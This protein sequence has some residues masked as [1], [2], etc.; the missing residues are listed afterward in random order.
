MAQT[1]KADCERGRALYRPHW[2]NVDNASGR[3]K[4]VLFTD[5]LVWTGSQL[6]G[7]PC[8]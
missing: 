6:G 1:I 7:A 3:E 8:C 2:Y 4:T 5:K